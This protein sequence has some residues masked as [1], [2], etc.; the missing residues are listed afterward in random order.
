MT[1]HR[2]LIDAAEKYVEMSENADAHLVSELGAAHESLKAA[3]SSAKA[4][5]EG[6][7]TSYVVE[8]E[9][10]GLT[11]TWMRGDSKSAQECYREVVRDYPS[12]NKIWLLRKDDY[13]T[14]I[15]V[16]EKEGL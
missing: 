15:S 6:V 3:I 2:A 4:A 10:S 9:R 13:S 16:R 5:E 8:C 11:E 1:P 14:V 12:A 7:E